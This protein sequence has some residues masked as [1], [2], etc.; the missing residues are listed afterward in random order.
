MHFKRL[1]SSS[2]FCNQA[3]L[4]LSLHAIIIVLDRQTAVAEH[5]P[6]LLVLSV[7][8]TSYHVGIDKTNDNN[9]LVHVNDS[10][11]NIFSEWE[12]GNAVMYAKIGEEELTVHV[13]VPVICNL[14]YL[15]I[16]LK[17][18]GVKYWN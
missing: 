12:L 18:E 7:N 9:Y 10:K 14:S 5:E 11:L 8:G 1:E 6:Y 4:A 15:Y 16:S 3:R 17:K 13:S 2:D